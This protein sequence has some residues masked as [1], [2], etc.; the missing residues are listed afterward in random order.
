MSK[1]L[2]SQLALNLPDTDN[3]RHLCCARAFIETECELQWVT[4]E[5]EPVHRL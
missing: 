3:R 5:K 4:H 1:D 2:R